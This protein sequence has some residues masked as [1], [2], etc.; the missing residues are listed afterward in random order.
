VTS[1]T[2]SSKRWIIV[3]GAGTQNYF[4]DCDDPPPSPPKW[5]VRFYVR[6]HPRH[7]GALHVVAVSSIDV[8]PSETVR[9]RRV[10]RVDIFPHLS[11]ERAG[12]LG[13]RQTLGGPRPFGGVSISRSQ[14]C[15]RC[16]WRLQIP[17]SRDGGLV[18]INVN[19]YD[20]SRSVQIL[21]R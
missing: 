7:M 11:A 6:V 18:E 14:A 19:P 15:R 3:G 5:V 9:T 2:G 17:S 4:R 10:Q 12:C 16:V 21:H 8:G 20:S 13:H 1:P